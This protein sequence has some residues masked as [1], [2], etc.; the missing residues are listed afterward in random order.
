MRNNMA[1]EWKPTAASKRIEKYH[2]TH[3]HSDVTGFGEKINKKGK[4]VNAKHNALMAKV[5]APNSKGLDI[6]R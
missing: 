3:R 4:F 6:K 2:S 1:K 5:D